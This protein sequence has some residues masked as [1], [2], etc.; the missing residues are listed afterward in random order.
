[1]NGGSHSLKKQVDVATL[2]FSKAFDTV[3][4]DDILGKVKHYSMDGNISN[5]LSNF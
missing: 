5:C 3:P 4:H 2:D 1:M